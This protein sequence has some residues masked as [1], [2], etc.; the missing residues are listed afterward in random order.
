[1]YCVNLG[2]RDALKGLSRLKYVFVPN[3]LTENIRKPLG[4]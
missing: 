4:F 1:M 3:V 2:E